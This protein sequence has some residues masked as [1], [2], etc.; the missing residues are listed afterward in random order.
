MG[1]RK[2]EE[3]HG[4]FG[5]KKE[6]MAE[7][8]AAAHAKIVAHFANIVIEMM[9]EGFTKAMAM[10]DAYVPLDLKSAVSAEVDAILAERDGNRYP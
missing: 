4:L 8:K 7:D 9:D 10:E 2:D 3:H 5:K 6:V 1:I